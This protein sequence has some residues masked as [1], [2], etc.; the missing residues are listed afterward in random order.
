MGKRTCKSNSTSAL[1]MSLLGRTLMLIE[2]VSVRNKFLL[3]LPVLDRL[4][5]LC[6]VRFSSLRDFRGGS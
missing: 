6:L 2:G 3:R 4:L 5:R 1:R